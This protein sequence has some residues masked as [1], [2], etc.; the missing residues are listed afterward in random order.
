MEAWNRRLKDLS[1]LLESCERTY[2]EPELFRMNANQF[3]QT[4]RTITFLIQK[5]KKKVPGF[6]SWYSKAVIEPWARD[7]VMLW[8]KNSRNKIEKQGD[9]DYHSTL[10]GTLIYSYFQ[11]ED[12]SS[13]FTPNDKDKLWLKVTGMIKYIKPRMTQEAFENSVIRIERKWVAN[14]LPDWELLQAFCYIYSQQHKVCRSLQRQIDGGGDLDVPEPSEVDFRARGNRQVAYISSVDGALHRFSSISIKR[15]PDFK[16]DEETKN[17]LL[18]FD[19]HNG[20]LVGALA[21]S[22]RFAETI[23]STTGQFF[24]SLLMYD[25]SGNCL[26]YGGTEYSGLAAKHL[27]WR[28]LGEQII[29]LSPSVFVV[30]SESWI[31]D[32]SDKSPHIKIKDRPIIGEKLSVTVLDKY[33]DAAEVTW[34][35]ERD[36]NGKAELSEPEYCMD[37]SVV[38]RTNNIISPVVEAFVVLSENIMDK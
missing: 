12:I 2:F 22:T 3:L 33:L 1:F 24:H 18:G 17:K 4:S 31:R 26:F 13:V 38:L 27:F 5:N 34:K 36:Q 29:S 20:T 37:R 15:D 11:R 23:F 32:F 30:T 7:S 25:D 9:I 10:I 16:I 6:D 14:S 21:S 28:M 35:I 8:S 19:D